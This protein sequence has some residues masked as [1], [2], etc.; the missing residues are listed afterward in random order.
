MNV[1]SHWNGL[2]DGTDRTESLLLLVD[3]NPHIWQHCKVSDEGFFSS[4]A[5]IHSLPV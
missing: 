4:V 3:T 2:S 1:A 5:G